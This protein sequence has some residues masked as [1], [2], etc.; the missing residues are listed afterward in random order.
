MFYIRN[1]LRQSAM[2]N[3]I[4]IKRLI[5][6]IL[7]V[8]VSLYVTL[9]AAH[10]QETKKILIVGDS[11]VAGYGLAPEQSFPAQLEAKL[12][13]SDHSISVFNAGVSG[14]TS[15]GGMSRLEWVLSSHEGLDLVI[16][17][18]GGNDALRG[19]Q[20]EITRN[21]MDKMASILKDKNI[22]TLVA[23]MMAPPNL[24]QVYGDNFNRIYPE[25]ALKY[26]ATLY[27]FYLDG[28]AGMLDL[29][30]NDRIHPNDAGVKYI[31]GRI[32]PL[33]LELVKG[34]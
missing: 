13:E 23:G 28:V 29:N 22:P 32:S 10:A 6:T 25:V 1:L 18:F 8:I 11:L 24:G 33:V 2:I 19:I 21:N 26:D 20:P 14:D 34:K 3:Y 16:L 31:V 17:L 4:A 9:M 27:P 12:K 15:S 7:A 30:Q 5:F